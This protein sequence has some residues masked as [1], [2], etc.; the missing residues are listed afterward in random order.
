MTL[1]QGKFAMC[2]NVE[3]IKPHKWQLNLQQ[4]Q[5]GKNKVIY[6]RKVIST[7]EIYDRAMS[8][9]K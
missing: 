1:R 4:I 6:Q 2:Q 9:Y 3:N 5:D 8:R 7:L